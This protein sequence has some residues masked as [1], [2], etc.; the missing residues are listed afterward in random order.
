M[1]LSATAAEASREPEDRAALERCQRGD[2]QAFE[3]VVHKYM[4]R[5]YF[6]ALG[7]VGNHEDALDLSQEAF[8]RAFRAIQRFDLRQQFFTWYY[9]ILRNI[10]L[11]HLRKRARAGEIAVNAGEADLDELENPASCGLPDPAAAAEQSE[12]NEQLWMAMRRLNA[13]D[14]EIL[15]LREIE[16]CAYAEI[17]ERLEI[18]SGTVMSRLFNARRRLRETLNGILS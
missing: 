15:L 16:G 9:R 2:A 11:N 5:A 14:R 4:K 10:C 1:Q 6:T 17:A 12:L 7:L 18:P 13:A 3:F 8:V